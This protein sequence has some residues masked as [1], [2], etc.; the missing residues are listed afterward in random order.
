MCRSSW[1]NSLK[2]V[3]SICSINRPHGRFGNQY[4]VQRKAETMKLLALVIF[5]I[6]SII[7]VF[8]ADLQAQLD[9]L[10]A[11]HKGKIAFYAKDLKTGATVALDPDRPVGTASVI[12][13]PIMLETF[14]EIKAGKHR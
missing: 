11:Q 6:F 10:A 3:K 14:Y 1:K 8:A 12:K 13:V 4:P 7:P 5:S 9:A 2:S